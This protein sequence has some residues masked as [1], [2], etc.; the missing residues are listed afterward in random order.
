VG[1]SESCQALLLSGVTSPFLRVNRFTSGG[2]ELDRE[3]GW[4]FDLIERDAPSG[5]EVQESL[6]FLGDA[7]FEVTLDIEA[8][9]QV[10]DVY[11]L[12]KRDVFGQDALKYFEAA[13]VFKA[14]AGRKRPNSPARTRLV[15][16]DFS[17]RRGPSGAIETL[18][19]VLGDQSVGTRNCEAG[20]KKKDCEELTRLHTKEDGERRTR[21]SSIFFPRSQAG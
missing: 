17:K 7:E 19:A 3:A 18:G 15:I 20:R 11:R 10:E 6:A 12:R 13:D 16:N 2:K 1:G 21:L 9:L 5:I 14:S 4:Y 8:S